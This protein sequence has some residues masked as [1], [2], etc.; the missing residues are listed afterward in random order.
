MRPI[1]PFASKLR[2]QNEET[3]Q[4]FPVG[5]VLF[6]SDT[7]SSFPRNRKHSFIVLSHYLMLVEKVQGYYER[8]GLGI[9]TQLGEDLTFKTMI[10]EHGRLEHIMLK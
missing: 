6:D 9:I 4:S 1:G 7:A 5:T 3:G 8:R 10:E 2:F